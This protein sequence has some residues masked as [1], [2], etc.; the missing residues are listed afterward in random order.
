MEGFGGLEHSEICQFCRRLEIVSPVRPELSGKCSSTMCGD[1]M[2]LLTLNV[3]PY[4]S[5]D[6]VVVFFAITQCGVTN[7]KPGGAITSD[8]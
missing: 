4:S 7:Q 8:V 5:L 3:C 2:N 6:V 1:I